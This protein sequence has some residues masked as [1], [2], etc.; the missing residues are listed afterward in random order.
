MQNI[1]FSGVFSYPL[2][3]DILNELG[4]IQSDLRL[5]MM[6]FAISQKQDVISYR[7][8]RKYFTKEFNRVN[9]N[10]G[11]LIDAGYISMP[12]KKT[13]VITDKGK[14]AFVKIMNIYEEYYEKFQKYRNGILGYDED[15]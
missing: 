10:N 5:L 6:Y 8:I 14:R 4:I 12:T 11:H 2:K 15:D 1:L 3:R 7:L 13:V 9:K